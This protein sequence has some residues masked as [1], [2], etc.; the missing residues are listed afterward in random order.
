M[1]IRTYEPRDHSPLL[2]LTVSTFEP[3][4]ENYFRTLMGEAVFAHQHGAWRDDYATQVSQLHDPHHAKHVAVCEVDGDITGYVA[5]VVDNDRHHG[6]IDILAVDTTSRGQGVGRALCEHA[7]ADM[8]AQ[9]VE[10][11]EVGTGDDPFH[12][13]ARALY[14][15]LGCTPL[16][17]V[18]Y[19]KE[20]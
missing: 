6:E 15:S 20:L 10:V 16:P 3:F 4:Y 2:Q 11:V 9:G 7:F 5:W 8:K 17:A 18:V 12:Q 19:F 1:R 14:E 13:P